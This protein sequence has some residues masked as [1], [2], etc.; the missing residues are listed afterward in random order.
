[1]TF[2]TVSFSVRATSTLT[3]SP[4]SPGGRIHL[5]DA[6]ADRNHLRVVPGVDDG[7]D[8]ISAESGTDLHQ[9]V[10]IGFLVDF[11]IEV[12][13][14]EIRAVCRKPGE[15]F[16]SDAGREF[17]SFHRC[18]EEQDVGF[19]FL[20]K[21]HDDLGIR[22]NRERFKT[23]V[24]REEDG[25]DTVAEQRVGTVRDVVTEENRFNFDAEF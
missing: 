21:I 8:D 18:A 11:I 22:K 19:V 2:I 25:L 23:F 10:G 15:L 20:D 7:R 24:L 14:L 13:N 4:L 1:M 6:V 17:A 16:G 9:F 12:I 3:I 5:H